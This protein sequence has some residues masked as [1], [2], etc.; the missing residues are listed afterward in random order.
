MD[1]EKYKELEIVKIRAKERKKYHQKRI[2]KEERLIEELEQKQQNMIM[3][4]Q[5][6]LF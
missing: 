2:R 6:K 5:P 4:G 1:I 3:E